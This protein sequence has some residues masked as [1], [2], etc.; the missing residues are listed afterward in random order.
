MDVVP[1]GPDMDTRTA[2]AALVLFAPGVSYPAQDDILVLALDELGAVKV[3]RPSEVHQG[4]RNQVE[5]SPHTHK[6]SPPPHTQSDPCLR[7]SPTPRN[8]PGTIAN[9]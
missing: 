8:K 5:D 1:F 4:R 3:A 7:T 9:I 6:R 2:R